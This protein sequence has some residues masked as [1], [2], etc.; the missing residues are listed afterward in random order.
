MQ[1]A[2]DTG[3]SIQHIVDAPTERRKVTLAAVVEPPSVGDHHEA[4]NE[5]NVT[6]DT[7]FVLPDSEFANLEG[8]Y[9]DWDGP[10]LDFAGFLNAETDDKTA[11]YASSRQSLLV[12]HSTPVAN[13]TCQVQ[14]ANSFHNV[15]IPAQPSH[16]VRSLIQR[17]KMKTD[18]QRIAS[19]ILH[20][21]K[22][23]PLMILRHNALPPFIHPIL[24]SSNVGNNDMEPLTNCMSLVHMISSG[25][26]GSR[27][28][29]WKNVRLECERFCDEVR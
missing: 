17:P 16:N 10:S 19:L 6:L 24:V 11:Q 4:S 23:Y 3:P 5:G 15:S 27:K 20:T 7:T 8:D 2:K 26:Q 22:S 9:F 21:L 25:I 18:G 14:E 28:L 13:Q 1:T 12:Q 29:F